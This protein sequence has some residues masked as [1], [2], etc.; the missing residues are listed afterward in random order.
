MSKY[1]KKGGSRGTRNS[2]QEDTE[3]DSE[4]EVEMFTPHTQVIEVSNPSFSGIKITPFDGNN[5]RSWKLRM[6]AVLEEHDLDD[7]VLKSETIKV[8]VKSEKK[9]RALIKLHLADSIL[10]LMSGKTSIEIWKSLC[11]TYERS[12]TQL[13]VYGWHSLCSLRFIEGKESLTCYM[14]RFETCV[15][16]LRSTGAKLEEIDVI[17]L[18]LYT[19]PSS[20][21]SVVDAIQTLSE[22]RMTMELVKNRL[23]DFELKLKRSAQLEAETVVDH[24]QVSKVFLTGATSGASSSTGAVKC[25][26]CGLGNHATRNCRMDLVRCHKCGK[27]GHIRARCPTRNVEGDQN[28]RGDGA[29]SS[30]FGNRGGTAQSQYRNERDLTAAIG[31]SRQ[32]EDFNAEGGYSFLASDGISGS[33]KNRGRRRLCVEDYVV[34]F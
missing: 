24:E 16:K 33:S 10:A 8:S 18:F 14:N 5:F 15:Q 7:V 2:R 6:I 27:F 11:T 4:P 21:D 32:D 30:S 31:F 34:T 23:L 29:E 28:Y 9:C 26:K 13:R 12:S 20:Y 3:N 19:L 1:K 25:E 22:N 17:S